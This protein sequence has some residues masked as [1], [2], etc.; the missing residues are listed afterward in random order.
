MT[1]S[2]YDVTPASDEPV[3]GWHPGTPGVPGTEARRTAC[4][5]PRTGRTAAADLVPA[6]RGAPRA[7]VVRARLRPRRRPGRVVRAGRAARRG[8]GGP[9]AGRAGD[10]ASRRPAVDGELRVR[11]VPGHRAVAGGARRRHHEPPDRRRP[12]AGRDGGAQRQP[13][14]Q[15]HAARARGRRLRPDHRTRAGR[16]PGCIGPARDRGRTADRAGRR[17]APTRRAGRPV[18]PQ[19]GHRGA[20]DTAVRRPGGAV[21]PGTGTRLRVLAVAGVPLPRELLP[22]ARQLGC[23]LPHHPHQDQDAQAARHPRAR[24][25]VRQAVPR[26]RPRHRPDRLRQVHDARRA[27]RPRQRDPCR[28]HRHGRGPDRV[29][30]RAQEGDHQPA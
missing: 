16:V 10:A 27:H 20:Q 9:A 5:T 21:R 19:Q 13:R 4:R 1:D 26:T 11:L 23:G 30:A 29:H 28:P 2:V 18:G 17:V 6:G 8:A 3:A 24:R 7:R 14:D 12:H 15:L 25:R 22:A